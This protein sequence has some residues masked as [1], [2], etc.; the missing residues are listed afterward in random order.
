MKKKLAEKASEFLVAQGVVS[1]EEREV[2][3]YGIYSLGIKWLPIMLFLLAAQMAGTLLDGF[4]MLFA[5]MKIRKYS[6]GYH[7]SSLKEMSDHVALPV[8]TELVF[9]RIYLLRCR[10]SC[11]IR[12]CRSDVEY[13][14]SY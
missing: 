10:I 5:F 4:I 1:E 6:G 11:F 2:Y 12:N 9:Y 3:E 7:A 13:L 8:G 14:Q